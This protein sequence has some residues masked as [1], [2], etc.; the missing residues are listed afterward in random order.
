[1]SLKAYLLKHVR[2]YGPLIH[3]TPVYLV[4]PHRT[5]EFSP[6]ALFNLELILKN[7]KLTKRLAFEAMKELRLF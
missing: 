4:P 7:R 5:S 2:G 6:L 1:M 3:P